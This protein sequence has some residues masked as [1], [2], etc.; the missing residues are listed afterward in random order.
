MWACC[1]PDVLRCSRIMS[2][3]SCLSPYPSLASATFSISSSFSSTARTRCGNRLST[4]NGPATRALLL[5]YV[6]L[7][8]EVLVVARWQRWRR[9]SPADAL[10]AV[11]TTRQETFSAASG[12]AIVS[13]GSRGICHSSQ[14]VPSAGVQLQLRSG[15]SLSPGTDLP[16][17]RRFRRCWQLTFRVT[18]V[19]HAGTHE[20]LSDDRCT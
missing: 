17:C 18:C 5:S 13:S 11:S 20:A 16:D 2:A 6:G 12:Q 10:C 19:A 3:K 14:E 4:V 15:S 9:L 8:I 7:V 1:T